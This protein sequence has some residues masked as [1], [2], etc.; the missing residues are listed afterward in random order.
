MRLPGSSSPAI[1]PYRRVRLRFSSLGECRSA[2]RTRGEPSPLIAPSFPRKRESR[3]LQP[4]PLSEIKHESQ[5]ADPFSLYAYRGRFTL[6]SIRLSLRRH[7]RL[8]PVIP[9]KAGIQMITDKPAARN[10]VQI[11]VSGS[12]L[13]L[14]E[15][16]RMRVRRAQARLAGETLTLT[17]IPKLPL[18]RIRLSP[19]ATSPFSF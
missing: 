10:Q 3:R 11:A 4:S 1:I 9:A 14:W 19:P 15:K 6:N 17:A 2:Q 13:P 5:S 8:A 18:W 7:S 16:A 12:L